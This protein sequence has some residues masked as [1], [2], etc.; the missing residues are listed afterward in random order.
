MSTTY[1]M[2]LPTVCSVLN[3]QASKYCLPIKK[4]CSVTPDGIVTLCG[5]EFNCTLCCGENHDPYFIPFDTN[6]HIILQTQFF[7]RF[8]L[9]P[10]MPDMGFGSWITIDIIDQN[11]VIVGDH[12]SFSIEYFVGWNGTNSY[13]ILKLFPD[14]PDFP[15]CFSIKYHVYR[16][17]G[18]DPEEYPTEGF[19]TQHF[20][21]VDSCSIGN[22]YTIQGLHDKFDCE[23]NYYQLP[24]NSF[25]DVPF[26][27]EN[28]IQILGYEEQAEPERETII[29]NG[30]VKTQKIKYRKRIL[31]PLI[32][33]FM[34]KYLEDRVFSGSQVL[35]NGEYV[36]IEIENTLSINDL[37]VFNYSI[38]VIESC[39]TNNC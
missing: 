30:N 2:E 21:L 39:K 24:L 35:I 18:G 32:P 20:K 5:E 9:D 38:L 37:C 34:V 16:N 7:D 15:T 10:T 33:L 1:F 4:H 28:K 8:N 17:I 36:T 13:Q 19:C 3:T 27:Y 11:G 31:F 29:V 25:G 23:G 12:T 22:L 6:E 26:V 14:V